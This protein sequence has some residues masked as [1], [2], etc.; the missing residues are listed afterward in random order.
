GYG[1]D[2]TEAADEVLFVIAIED[3]GVDEAYGFEPGIEVQADH[4]RQPL[5]GGILVD[6]LD[7]DGGAHRSGLLGGDLFDLAGELGAAI[8]RAY[9]LRVAGHDASIECEGIDDR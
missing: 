4:E 5:A 9:E 1:E 3:D 8:E 7:L 6:A 2:Q